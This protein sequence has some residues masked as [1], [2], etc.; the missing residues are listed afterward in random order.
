MANFTWKGS[1]SKAIEWLPFGE[2]MVASLRSIS[3]G[4]TM[5]QRY[6]PANNITISAQCNPDTLHIDAGFAVKVVVYTQSKDF[7]VVSYRMQ[8]DAPVV[9]ERAWNKPIGHRLAFTDFKIGGGSGD[10]YNG[11]F[12]VGRVFAQIAGGLSPSQTLLSVGV[13][14]QYKGAYAIYTYTNYNDKTLG[15]Y[16]FT[17]T[18][19]GVESSLVHSTQYTQ[20]YNLGA[21]VFCHG[22]SGLEL[23]VSEEVYGVAGYLMA[24]GGFS[25]G[26][27]YK[28]QRYSHAYEWA[29]GGIG[30][31]FYPTINGMEFNSYTVGS[32][33]DS[34]ET[35]SYDG[36]SVAMTRSTQT[37]VTAWTGSRDVE[38][39]LLCQVLNVLVWR[40]LVRD[41]TQIQT[42]NPNFPTA[43]SVNK[44]YNCV[45]VDGVEIFRELVYTF[46]DPNHYLVYLPISMP[47]VGLPTGIASTV[48]Q[49]YGFS[50]SYGDDVVA[51][52]I[53]GFPGT[54]NRKILVLPIK[55]QNALPVII[56]N[57]S[58][59]VAEMVTTIDV[60][61][62]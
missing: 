57:Y 43:S 54:S 38:S 19:T 12:Y 13:L 47:P 23:V 56:G 16:Q 41:Y 29:S 51:I 34:Y 20:D 7:F 9:V 14:T 44:A 22:K 18:P 40:E 37:P 42:A 26:D 49:L 1:F 21:A 30:K 32:R 17:I 24:I 62:S 35:Y 8:N 36:E 3:G 25:T 10:P 39:T 4:G 5:Q 61:M 45:A 6:M 27:I 31:F 46:N 2:A 28:I 53:P 60:E 52:Q 11:Y 48:T 55:N 33:I 59:G 50:F 15:V 58:A